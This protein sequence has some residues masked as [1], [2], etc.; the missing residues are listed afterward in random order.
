[1]YFWTRK[2]R[3]HLYMAR[4]HNGEDFVH[5]GCGQMR[6]TQATIESIGRMHAEVEL[7]GQMG[8][9]DLLESPVARIELLGADER[10]RLASMQHPQRRRDMRPLRR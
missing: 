6:P 8:V 3:L 4:I 5:G 10:L 9:A 1:M 7:L 2:L